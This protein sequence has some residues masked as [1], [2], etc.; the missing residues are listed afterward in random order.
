MKTVI[1]MLTRCGAHDD[2]V[3]FFHVTMAVRIVYM[4]DG[5]AF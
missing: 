1:D 5:V 3:H 4:S 2:T